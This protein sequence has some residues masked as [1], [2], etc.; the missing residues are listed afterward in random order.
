MVSLLAAARTFGTALAASFQRQAACTTTIKGS[1]QCSWHLDRQFVRL[2]AL[3]ACG[4]MDPLVLAHVI[5]T[6]EL[7]PDTFPINLQNLNVS[8][9]LQPLPSSRLGGPSATGEVERPDA[10]GVWVAGSDVGS[11]SPIDLNVPV[12]EVPCA[13]LLFGNEMDTACDGK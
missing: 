4:F 9:L 7:V 1:Y 13:I 6:C 11:G 5:K 2:K 3:K 8:Q 12:P 10:S